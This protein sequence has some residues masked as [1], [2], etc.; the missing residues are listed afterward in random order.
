MLYVFLLLEHEAGQ[1]QFSGV[2]QIKKDPESKQGS[3]STVQVKIL[4]RAGFKIF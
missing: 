2:P 4:H 1:P 3:V